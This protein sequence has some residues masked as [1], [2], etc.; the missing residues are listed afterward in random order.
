MR[1]SKIQ[2][3]REFVER[4]ATTALAVGVGATIT[5]W[6]LGADEIKAMRAASAPG[7]AI[8]PD[9]SW[10]EGIR[11]NHSQIFDMPIPTGGLGLLHVRN[12]IHTYRSAFGQSYPH[13]LA[14]VGLYGAT[15]LLAYAP[16]LKLTI[17]V[18]LVDS[19]GHYGGYD[20]V[21]KLFEML[22]ELA[23]SG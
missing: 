15:T 1:E 14:I 18:D 23:A 17:A 12:Y 19:L 10:L 16:S 7:P 5:P 9:N 13:V 4:I 2:N 20:A 3:R 8:K 22:E 11:G 6:A 21:F